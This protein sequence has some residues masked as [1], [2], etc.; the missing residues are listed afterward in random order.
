MCGVGLLI[1]YDVR[2]NTIPMEFDAVDWQILGVLQHDA[3][4][5]NRELADRV[6]LSPSASLARVKSLRERGVIVGYA[7]ELDLAR[8]GRPLQAIVAIR[9]G[10][11]H[12]DTINRFVADMVELDETLDLFHVTGEADYLLHLAVTDPEHLR[13]VVLDALTS[14]PEVAQVTTSLVFEHHRAAAVKRP[15]RR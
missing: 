8:I 15:V 12:R 7:A 11:H 9:L 6:G 1:R 2:M 4:I 14:R 10:T 3:R 5:T 13:N